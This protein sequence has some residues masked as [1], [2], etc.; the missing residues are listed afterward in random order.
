[1]NYSYEVVFSWFYTQGNA[2]FFLR[3]FNEVKGFG[4]PRFYAPK[5]P[6]T[7]FIHLFKSYRQ[8]VGL[9]TK[10]NFSF[11]HHSLCYF[12]LTPYEYFKNRLY[13]PFTRA[14][15]IIQEP[16]ILSKNLKSLLRCSD[17]F[18]TACR[19]ASFKDINVFSKEFPILNYVKNGKIFTLER[20]IEVSEAFRKLFPAMYLHN[21]LK[22]Y[23]MAVF[24]INPKKIGNIIPYKD[25]LVGL[26]P[27]HRV[28]MDT[29]ICSKRTWVKKKIFK[30]FYDS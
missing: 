15:L 1:M 4:H 2:S 25:K 20:F 7:L 27:Q 23:P 24:A 12:G 29:L 28:A 8:L 13:S 19:P 18:E 14:I 10:Y 5:A 11:P 6:K 3:M 9:T 26:E 30:K 22:T 21:K 16:A 17:Y